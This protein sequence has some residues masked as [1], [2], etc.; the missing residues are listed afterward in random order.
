MKMLPATNSDIY[1]AFQDF[2]FF[3]VSKTINSF[4]SMSLDQKHKQQ[5]QDRNQKDGI[6]VGLTENEKLRC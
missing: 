3:L 4:S 2:G 1:Q 6:F 5:N